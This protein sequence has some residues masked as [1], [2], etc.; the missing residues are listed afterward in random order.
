[1]QKSL[2]FWPPHARVYC[3]SPAGIVASWQR[4]DVVQSA[5]RLRMAGEILKRLGAMGGEGAATE[6]SVDQTR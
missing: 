2:A 6:G 4:E 1:M 5:S 3:L